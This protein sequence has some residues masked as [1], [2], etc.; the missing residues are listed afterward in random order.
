MIPLLHH[1][2]L[3]FSYSI[4]SMKEQATLLG[5]DH[6]DL[7]LYLEHHGYKNAETKMLE[8]NAGEQKKLEG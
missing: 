5:H 7:G 8:N 4:C 6:E 1:H 3:Q 2:L